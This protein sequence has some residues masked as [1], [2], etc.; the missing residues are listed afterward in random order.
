MGAKLLPLILVCLL[1][2]GLKRLGLLNPHDASTIGKLLSTLALPA[3]ILRALITAPLTIELIYLPLSA[4]I[5]VLGLTAVGLL[6]A[7]CLPWDRP[8]KGSLAT[9]FPTFEGGAVGY[10]LMLLAFGEVG[11]SL[12]V[13]FDLAQAMY[14]L[15]VVY[16]L[17]TWFGKADITPG[18]ILKKLFRTPF[19]WAIILG[20]ALNPV[21]ITHGPFLEFLDIIAQSFL[22]LILLLLSLEFQVER[23]F[24]PQFVGLSLLKAAC[25]LGLGWLAASLF[26]LHGVERIAVLVGAAMPPSMLTLL[27]A[28]ENQLNTRFAAGYVSVAIPVALV[29]LVGLLEV[30]S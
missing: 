30:L 24:L 16:S 18:D 21:G 25:G 11:L 4:F 19:F 7:H 5:V 13:L 1:G 15:T 9:T 14:L 3:L 23:R 12:I 8:T 28:K 26:G 27:F 22:L 17:S 6:L 20:L 2:Y 29:F 10:P